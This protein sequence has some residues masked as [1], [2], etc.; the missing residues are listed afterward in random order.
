MIK[1]KTQ[2]ME[3]RD[4]VD[5]NDKVLYSVPKHEIY[6]KKLSHRIVHVLV[7][8]KKG[9]IFLQK[10]SE[11]LKYLPGHW[12]TSAGGHAMAGESYEEAAKRE[13]KEEINVPAKNLEEVAHF[14]H[15]VS[16][17]IKHVRIFRMDYDGPINVNKEDVS[18]GKWFS[19]KELKALINKKDFVND[20]WKIALEKGIEK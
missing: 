15:D 8:N 20:E 13:L 18:E 19:R 5:E 2:K 7:F 1:Q 10:R 14:I 17:W 6:G 4:V 11:K 3:Y 9:E 16:G 12:C